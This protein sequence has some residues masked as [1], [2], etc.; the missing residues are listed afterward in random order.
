MLRIVLAAVLA[1]VGMF[2][3]E[4]VHH[5]FTPL[6]EMG[7]KS[8]PRD[9]KLMP[10]IGG[11]L[12]EPGFYFFPHME[13]KADATSAE[14]EAAM[15]EY[16]KKQAS[17]PAGII[18]LAPQGEMEMSPR[19]LG[20]QFGLDVLCGLIAGILVC[21]TNAPT[22]GKRLAAVTLLGVAPVLASELP[23]WNWY[24]YP[25]DFT[26]AAAVENVVGFFVCG[27]IVAAI[28]RP[29]CKTAN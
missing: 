11:E 9:E 20:T 26:F 4:F 25:L 6:G 18:V 22:F 10:A 14:K 29:C 21:I 1:G 27:L 16:S 5:M 8:I 13:T 7:V 23:N 12:T 19:T 17:G 3:W 15:K 24:R 28:V 2:M